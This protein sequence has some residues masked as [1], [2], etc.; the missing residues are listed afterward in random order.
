M[1]NCVTA[2]HCN[3]IYILNLTNNLKPAVSDIQVQSQALIKMIYAAEN[4]LRQ[5]ADIILCFPS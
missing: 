5:A 2:L 3:T 1:Y 4:G